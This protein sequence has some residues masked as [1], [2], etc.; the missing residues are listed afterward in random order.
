MLQSSLTIRLRGII[1]VLDDQVF[2]PVIIP[3]TEIAIQDVLH[4]IRI[5][6]LC[7]DACAAH[8][9]NCGI[10]TAKLVLG[11]AERMILRGGLREPYVS[12]VPAEVAGF[13]RGGDVF[14]DDNGA[15]GGVDEPG[16]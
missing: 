13:E 3:T 14:F 7:I 10:S 16:A 15:T 12:T 5:P 11:V 2:G 6:L 4:P 8:M 1:P 9:R